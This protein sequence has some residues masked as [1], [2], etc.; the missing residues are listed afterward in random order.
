MTVKKGTYNNR[1][2]NT[3]TMSKAIIGIIITI[4]LAS[5]PAIYFYGGLVQRVNA[6][7]QD[8]TDAISTIINIQEKVNT[9]EQIASGT[10][11][12]L[13]DIKEDLKE[14]KIDLKQ[15]IRGQLEVGNGI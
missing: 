13:I 5:I 8:H 1:T 7:E 6:V 9:L 3:I 14:I 15:V 12:A 10:E 11:V 4:I 2:D